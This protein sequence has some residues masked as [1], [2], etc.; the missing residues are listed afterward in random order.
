MKVKVT[1]FRAG[2][3][4]FLIGTC[5]SAPAM[6][7]KP[8]IIQIAPD[9]YIATVT[10]H[11]GIFANE[12]T[13]KRKAV[14]AAN[15]FAAKEGKIAVARSLRS[16]PAYPGH[17]ATVEYQF[18][19][20]APNDPEAKRTTLTPIADVTI[21]VNAPAP[22]A[23]PASQSKPD[24]YAELLKL[25]DLRKRGLLSNEEFEMQKA[26]VLAGQ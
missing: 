4:A 8:D 22:A 5:A 14:N 26:K 23:Q 20:V 15:E 11:A 7:G 9:T 16:T 19:V 3:L 13:T 1:G 17:F 25:D 2:C 21:D 6:A 10:N 12:A 24:I 18:I